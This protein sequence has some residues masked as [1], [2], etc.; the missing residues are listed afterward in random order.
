MAKK[1]G[2]K[3]KPSDSR[4]SELIQLRVLAT[5]KEAF[6]AAAKL[7]GLTLSA[8]LRVRMRAT[9]RLELEEN[10]ETVPFLSTGSR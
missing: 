8:W 5:E 1:R 10:G 6:E 7:A 2:P 9:S 4:R 3:P